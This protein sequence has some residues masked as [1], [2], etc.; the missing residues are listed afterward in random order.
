MNFA[1]A[2]AWLLSFAN[3]EVTPLDAAP[4]AKLELR[5]L[6]ELL[7]RLGDPQRGRG[8]VHLTGSKGKGSTAAMIAAMLQA[9]GERT[10]LYTS[11]HLHTIRERMR[12]DGELI[13]ED[14]FAALTSALRPEAEAMIAAGSRLT[15]FEL[16]T[17]LGFFCFRERG[18]TWQVVEVGLGGT[19]DATNVLDEKQ[20]CVFT[21]IGLEHTA[22]LGDTVAQIATDKAGILRP[23]V[24]AVMAVQRESA[25]EVLR[26]ACAAQGATLA[27]V[28][29]VC[30]LSR[31][32]GG[33]DGQ[34]LRL[35]TPRAD[36]K[37]RLPLAGRFQAEN[38][39]TA[40]LGME[41]L[42]DAGVEFT[43]QIAARALAEVRWPGRL[44]VLKRS[45]LV[46]VD[47]AHSPDSAK[48]LAQAL[49]EDFSYRTLYLVFGAS[50]DKN[51]PEIAAA[52]ATLDPVVM[53][54]AADHPRSAP[55]ATAG[56]A[57]QDQGMLVRLAPDVATAMDTAMSEAGS[58]DLVLA[59]GSL[60]VVA[61]ARAAVLGLT[62]SVA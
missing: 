55:A 5:P 10:A 7:T 51:L 15:T 16:L 44:E 27:E 59:T 56:Q 8:T 35:R 23:G 46:M 53:A 54:T 3:Y 17:A 13:S 39:A 60:F 42:V 38:A 61:E 25:A 2:A 6:R 31:Q 9:A 26:A 41:Q 20:L 36:Y 37:L 52:F 33:A 47:G 19:L 58:G 57:F 30:Q 62:P 4:A 28:A 29:A 14:E 32:K 1:D 21:P 11:P 34:E 50:R 22:I 24:R 48:R 49:K 43:P 12:V 18:A 45:P 40:V